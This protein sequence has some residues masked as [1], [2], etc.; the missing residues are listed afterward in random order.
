MNE[1]IPE[2]VCKIGLYPATLLMSRPFKLITVVWYLQFTSFG[3][4]HPL[5]ANDHRRS[6]VSLLLIHY[7]GSVLV[8]F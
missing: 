7:T 1:I 8:L 4:D 6:L 3:V 5:A 2:G